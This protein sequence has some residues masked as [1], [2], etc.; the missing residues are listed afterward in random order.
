MN[1]RRT[2]THRNGHRDRDGETRLGTVHLQI[3]TLRRG[4][5]F[6]AFLEPR[7]RSEQALTAVIPEAYV[8]GVSTRQGDDLVQALGMTGL[9][10]SAGSA[11]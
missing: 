6:P 11:L 9:K 4:S 10:K 3:P 8:L 1:A 5:Y 2:A 7:R